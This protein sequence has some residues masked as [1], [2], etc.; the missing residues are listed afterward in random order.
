MSSLGKRKVFYMSPQISNVIRHPPKV[1]SI[2]TPSKFTISYLFKAPESPKQ[3]LPKLSKIS[4]L[5]SPKRY[6]KSKTRV[7]QPLFFKKSASRISAI[8][9]TQGDVKPMAWEGE[10]TEIYA[11]FDLSSSKTPNK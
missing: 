4:K 8:P 5:F 11:S 7:F 10:A 1:L 9:K 3:P 6:A 2:K